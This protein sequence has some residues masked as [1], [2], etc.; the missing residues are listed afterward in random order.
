VVA[1]WE[2]SGAHYHFD[3][4]KLYS[5]AVTSTTPAP[6]TTPSPAPTPT[7]TL[8][9]TPTPLPSPQVST[10]SGTTWAGKRSDGDYYEY[11]FQKDGTLQYKSPTGLWKNATWKQDGNK[12][13]MEMNNKYAEYEGII[14]GNKMQGNAWNVKGLKWTWV[15]EKQ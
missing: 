6:A 13:Y 9:P 4:F 14:T 5:G 1:D 12:I 10:V 11:Y 2:T 8:T 15:A 3:N 7:P